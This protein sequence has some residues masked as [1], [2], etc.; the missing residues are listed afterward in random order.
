MSRS[1]KVLFLFSE[2]SPFAKT[3]GLADVAGSL[4]GALK[5]L[6]INATA[7]GLTFQGR[8]VSSE[9]IVSAVLLAFLTREEDDQIKFLDTALRRLEAVL[10]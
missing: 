7:R 3:G 2:V 6:G 1:I 5:R 8:T 4:P 9:A 10:T